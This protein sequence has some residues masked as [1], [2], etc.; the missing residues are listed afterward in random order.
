MSSTSR[1]MILVAAALTLLGVRP[2]LAASAATIS[3]NSR[4][5]LKKLYAANPTAKHLGGKAKAI[6]VFPRILKA[7]FMVGAQGGEGAMLTGGKVSGYYR[8]LAASYG[9]Q[10]GPSLTSTR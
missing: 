1:R 10:A 6:L 8:T 2:A 3:T 5:G 4:A 9:F 7:G